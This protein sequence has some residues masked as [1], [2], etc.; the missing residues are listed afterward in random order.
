MYPAPNRAQAPVVKD[1]YDKSE[2]AAKAGMFNAIAEWFGLQNKLMILIFAAGF[3]FVI[4]QILAIV[5]LVLAIIGSQT[6]M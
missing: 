3:L 2:S 5:L 4:V 1:D 6:G